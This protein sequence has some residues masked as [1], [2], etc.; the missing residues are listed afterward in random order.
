M[1]KGL[2]AAHHP[3]HVQIRESD[4]AGVPDVERQGEAALAALFFG[5]ERVNFPVR[6][7]VENNFVADVV[8]A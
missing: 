5:L 6:C 4:I 1:G 8:L 2:I 7:V 3:I